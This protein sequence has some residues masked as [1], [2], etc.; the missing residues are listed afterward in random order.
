MAARRPTMP[1]KR[2]AECTG[3]GYVGTVPGSAA[4]VTVSGAIGRRAHDEVQR[5][6]PECGSHR[7][8]RVIQ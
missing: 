8:F 2:D 3:C 6:C 7:M 4:T 5:Y 1:G